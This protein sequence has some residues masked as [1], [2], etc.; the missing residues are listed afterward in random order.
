[1]VSSKS[2]TTQKFIPPN[3]KRQGTFTYI[4]GD[5][6]K[7]ERHPKPSTEDFP[8]IEIAPN[9]MDARKELVFFRAYW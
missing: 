5:A 7:V 8:D 1:M 3:A 4:S 6:A 9:S 2:R